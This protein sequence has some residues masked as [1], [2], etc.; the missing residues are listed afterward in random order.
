MTSRL[1]RWWH[2]VR[3]QRRAG[4][5]FLAA[6]ALVVLGGCGSKPDATSTGPAPSN[7]SPSLSGPFAEFDRSARGLVTR[8]AK[9]QAPATLT[10]DKTERI[11]LAIGEGPQLTNKIN[12]LLKDTQSTSAGPPIQ[13][14]SV[15]RATLRANPADADISP[16]DAVNLS[17]GS[18][19]QM[20]WT[21]FVHP[22]RPMERL[23]LTAFLEVP[24]DSGHIVSHEL[25]F[26]VPVK[27]TFAYTAEEVATHWGTWSAV[28]ATLV[29]VI[30]WFI[31]RRN[32]RRR[33]GSPDGPDD[34]P[35]PVE[36]APAQ[37]LA[38]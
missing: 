20:L 38:A 5:F 15:V 6:I 11:G 31:R 36:P 9:W 3:V 10:V 28:A 21:W 30:G 23:Q 1:A 8:E 14:G 37:Q 13:V 35:P 12:T 29:S 33:N 19:I 2:D 4:F 7:E 17:T 26:S 22:K 18:N 27:R 34:Q 24:L 25:G 32:R 16:S